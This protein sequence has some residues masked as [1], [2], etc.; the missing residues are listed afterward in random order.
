MVEAGA[1][2]PENLTDVT[3]KA[4][5]DKGYE[6]QD[7]EV[8]VF[9]DGKELV[10]PSSAYGIY[11]REYTRSH[12]LAQIQKKECFTVTFSKEHER[13]IKREFFAAGA[14][15]NIDAPEEGMVFTGRARLTSISSPAGKAVHPDIHM[16]SPL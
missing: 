16:P 12:Y 13:E 6:V 10:T 5:A 11:Q 7:Y 15:G 14:P 1:E 4:E 3:V 9:T 8:R 2:M